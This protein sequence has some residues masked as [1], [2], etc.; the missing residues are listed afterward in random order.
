MV[1]YTGYW[2]RFEMRTGLE[3]TALPATVAEADLDATSHSAANSFLW[4]TPLGRKYLGA[5]RYRVQ[6]AESVGPVQAAHLTLRPI[7]G[8]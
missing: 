1:L 5:E 3:Q 2:A 4:V 6:I 7:G 8:L